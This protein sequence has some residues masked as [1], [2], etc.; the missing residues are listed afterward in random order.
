ML[1][2]YTRTDPV[3]E[4]PASVFTQQLALQIDDIVTVRALLIQ[5]GA[6]VDVDLMENTSGDTICF[7]RDPFDIVL[8]LVQRRETMLSFEM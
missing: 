8:E 2:F 1:Q 5:A 3:W 6:R 7:L 4:S